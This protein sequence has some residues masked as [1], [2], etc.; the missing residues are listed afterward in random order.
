MQLSGMS[1]FCLRYVFVDTAEQLYK[2]LF[3]SSGVRLRSVREYVKKGTELRIVI[4]KIMKSDKEQFEALVKQIRNDALLLGH[5]DYD[6]MC[7]LLSG[8]EHGQGL[9][10]EKG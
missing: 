6:D 5:R 3:P 2:R 8:I 1:I 10:A 9:V 4:C 7:I